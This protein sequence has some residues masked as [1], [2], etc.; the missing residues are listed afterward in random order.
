MENSMTLTKTNL[1]EMAR[2]LG[3]QNSGGFTRLICNDFNYM[4]VNDHGYWYKVEEGDT[5]EK[6]ED[7][8]LHI[9]KLVPDNRPSNMK[10]YNFKSDGC[11][12]F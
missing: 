10:P 3:W 1:L 6:K 2:W 9:S 5:V 11:A 12:S 4:E 7:G 8:T